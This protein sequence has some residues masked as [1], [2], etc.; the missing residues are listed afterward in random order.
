MMTEF[1]TNPLNRYTIR[2]TAHAFYVGECHDDLSLCVNKIECTQSN[3]QVTEHSWCDCVITSAGACIGQILHLSGHT[4]TS[5]HLTDSLE[6]WEIRVFMHECHKFSNL[7]WSFLS[8]C[9][10]S[11]L[12]SCS[13]ISSSEGKVAVMMSLLRPHAGFQRSALTRGEEKM[14]MSV[15][16]TQTF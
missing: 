11:S 14:K 16:L 13:I 10:L 15:N 5:T 9:S 7:R 4:H 2:C 6:M 12:M 3:L 1:W 8:L